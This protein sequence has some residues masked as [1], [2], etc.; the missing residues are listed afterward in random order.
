MISILYLLLIISGCFL[1]VDKTIYLLAHLDPKGPVGLCHGLLV[2]RRPSS[3]SVNI[4]SSETTER[5]KLKLGM[6]L[7]TNEENQ[8]CSRRS[9][10]ISN[11][12]ATAAI[13]KMPLG[14]ICHLFS[15]QM[16]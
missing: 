12:A 7:P 3:S 10:P 8:I 9:D 2:R 16:N 6:H 14:A 4:F 13:L 11:M 1:L 15:E 5:M